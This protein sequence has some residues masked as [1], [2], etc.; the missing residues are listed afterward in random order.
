MQVTHL[1]VHAHEAK[2]VHLNFFPKYITLPTVDSGAHSTNAQFVHFFASDDNW[3]ASA[4]SATKHQ[5]PAKQYGTQYDCTQ[6]RPQDV[7]REATTGELLA[8]VT[9]LCSKLQV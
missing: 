2:T 1:L 9:V 7:E 4:L 3:I 8:G 6:I 5:S